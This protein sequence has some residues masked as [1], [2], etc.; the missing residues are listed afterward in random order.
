MLSTGA[1]ALRVLRL[2]SYSVIRFWCLRQRVTILR[3]IR[4]TSAVNTATAKVDR[5]FDA[6]IIAP[7][8]ASNQIA[9]AAGVKLKGHIKEVKAAVNPDDQAVLGLAFDQISD[10]LGKK[11]NLDARV[12]GRG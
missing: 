11:V 6:V 8:G 10:M 2:F 1:P 5:Q 9:I 4:L 3:E 12:A 7:V